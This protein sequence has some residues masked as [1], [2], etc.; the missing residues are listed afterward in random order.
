MND[1]TPVAARSG[2]ASGNAIKWNPFH[3]PQ[4]SIQAA[5]SGARGTPSKKLRYQ[6]DDERKIKGQANDDSPARLSISPRK[7]Y[8]RKNGIV[9]ATG[10]AIR[11][12]SIHSAIERRAR[13]RQRDSA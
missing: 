8:A 10:G 4:P 2:A 3:T 6:P 5:S 9:K 12:A 7:R 13:R 1:K 11:F